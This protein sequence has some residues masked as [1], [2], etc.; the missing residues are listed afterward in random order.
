M[1]LVTERNCPVLAL[2]TSLYQYLT[3]HVEGASGSCYRGVVR[4]LE[5]FGI[6]TINISPFQTSRRVAS[7]WRSTSQLL[8]SRSACRRSM[9]CNPRSILYIAGFHE[10]TIPCNK[11][12]GVRELGSLRVIRMDEVM[13]LQLTMESSQA[14]LQIVSRPSPAN[15]KTYSGTKVQ[16]PK[17]PNIAEFSYP[18]ISNM[19]GSIQKDLPEVFSHENQGRKRY[20][21]AKDL[22]VPGPPP[23]RMLII[24][25]ILYS[26]GM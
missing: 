4:S 1:V 15:T 13:Y 10:P 21:T 24:A 12:Y 20:H 19:V 6:P 25:S 11:K 5:V 14:F 26:T 9:P 23:L 2:V 22:I 3:L 18:A 8:E 17:A 7:K 16:T